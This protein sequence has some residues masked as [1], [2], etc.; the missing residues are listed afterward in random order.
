M[1][2]LNS[3]ASSWPKPPAVA[4]AMAN[5]VAQPPFTG[6]RGSGA[7][8]DTGSHCRKLLGNLLGANP[9]RIFFTSGATEAFNMVVRGLAPKR[10]VVTA[11]EHNAVLRP[12]YA[13]LP[14]D[15]I[16]VV[17]CGEDGFVDLDALARA[18]V[19]GVDVLFVNHC[20]NVTGAVQ[21]LAAAAKMAKKAGAVLVVDA[22]Q[23]AGVVP[24]DVAAL[25]VD[26]LV[27][28]GHKGLLG[29]AG[30]GGF[31]LREGQPLAASKFGGTGT[32]GSAVLPKGAE[33]FEVGTPNG[34]GM[35]GLAAGL[36]YVLATGVNTIGAKVD[37][38]AKKIAL[39]LAGMKGNALYTPGQGPRGG[40]V[41]FTVA[42]LLPADV[43]YILWHTYGIEVRTGHQCAPLFMANAG[44][45]SG[46]V[47]VSVS[48]LTPEGDVDAFLDAM[49]QITEGVAL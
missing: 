41:G 20:S 45:A 22:A 38:M 17:P 24:I 40:A 6:P 25:G 15:A 5:A 9:E 49:E 47:R 10:V 37:A 19:P 31:Y 46:L 44:L 34:P 36:E 7:P 39:A 29:P 16:E 12:L 8:G 32:E 48:A 28:T 4:K 27:F 3:A 30:I 14:G 43:G 23:S 42:G 33:M 1:I 35:A 2:Y 13:L 11:A 18:V 26:I 21:N